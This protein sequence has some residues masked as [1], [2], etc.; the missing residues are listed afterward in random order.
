MFETGKFIKQIMKAYPEQQLVIQKYNIS[1]GDI[2][3][4]FQ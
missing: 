2:L 3:N 1:N 4:T